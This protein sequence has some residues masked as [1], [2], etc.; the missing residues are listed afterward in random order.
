MSGYGGSG[1]LYIED[2]TNATSVYKHLTVDNGGYTASDQ[3]QEVEKLDLTK[4]SLESDTW[5]FYSYSGIHFNSTTRNTY[6]Y[7]YL[8]R[9]TDGSLSSSYYNHVS[10]VTITV[11]LPHVLYVDHLRVYPTCQRYE[12]FILMCVIQL[13]AI[14][15]I[16]V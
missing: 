12:N 6:D 2:Q 1:T 4:L 9:L 3:I 16:A 14:S 8:G 5:G 15:N 13:E 11:V 7:H 10:S